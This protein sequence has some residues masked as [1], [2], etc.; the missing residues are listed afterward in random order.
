MEIPRMVDR[1]AKFATE[2]LDGR[3]V[4]DRDGQDGKRGAGFHVFPTVGDQVA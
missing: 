1:Y 4:S 3:C 2:N